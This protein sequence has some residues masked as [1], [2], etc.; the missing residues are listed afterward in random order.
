MIRRYMFSYGMACSIGRWRW[1]T[2]RR[3]RASQLTEGA[4]VPASTLAAGVAEEINRLQRDPAN[5]PMQNGNYAGWRYTPLDQINR[6]NAKD[7]KIG[8]QVSTGFCGDTKAARW[9]STGCCF[10]RRRTPSFSTPS[11]SIVRAKS[12]GNIVRIQTRT[13][14]RWPAAISSI[15]DR[16][17]RTASSS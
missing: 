14:F 3:L 9:W 1:Y 8:W 5:W 2:R 16:P 6:A 13:P 4:S 15:A 17:M 12:S 11:T 10:S 7:L